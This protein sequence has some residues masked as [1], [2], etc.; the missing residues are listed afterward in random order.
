M[1]E[2]AEAFGAVFDLFGD[3][4]IDEVAFAAGDDDD[5]VFLPSP[6]SVVVVKPL[7]GALVSGNGRR[8]KGPRQ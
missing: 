7:H 1:E 5:L 3:H 6:S 2:L 8:S 4:E